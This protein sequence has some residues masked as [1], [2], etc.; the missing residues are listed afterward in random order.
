MSNICLFCF[1]LWK[2]LK[3]YKSK[4][5]YSEPLHAS[6]S[7]KTSH[8]ILSLPDPFVSVFPFCWSTS[9]EI[10]DMQAYLV[11]LCFADTAFLQIKG[12]LHFYKLKVVATVVEQVHQC[13]F[14]NSTCSLCVSES[15]FFIVI[16][17]M[18][19]QWSF[20]LLL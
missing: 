18:L 11:L 8:V 16:F 6:N 17:V 15:N 9:K 14:S 7:S 1:L 10:F 19:Y 4:E 13:H 20:T 5:N 3:I 2:F 12:L